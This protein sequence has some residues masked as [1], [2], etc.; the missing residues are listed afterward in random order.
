MI[1]H[2][3]IPH[4]L[5]NDRCLEGGTV[6]ADEKPG[7]GLDR[8]SARSDPLFAKLGAADGASS[9]EREE[10]EHAGIQHCAD[11]DLDRDSH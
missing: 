6:A 9:D 10:W 8:G 2:P 3:P 11:Q 4:L 5:D 1:I 7:L